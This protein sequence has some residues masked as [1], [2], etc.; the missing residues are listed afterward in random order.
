MG[1]IAQD[2]DA[3]GPAQHRVHPVRDVQDGA[4]SGAKCL[5]RCE[6]PLCFGSGQGDSWFILH[7]GSRFCAALDRRGGDPGA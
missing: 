1:T 5:Q 7:L 4:A 3:F 6:K 2:R